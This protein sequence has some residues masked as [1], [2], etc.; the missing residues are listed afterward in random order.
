VR[1]ALAHAAGYPAHRPFYARLG[2]EALARPGLRRADVVALAAAE[3][4][5]YPA[6]ARSLYSDIGFILLG[7]RL[8]RALGARL[9]VLVRDGVSAPLGLTTLGFVDLAAGGAG[10]W[11]RGR[12][13]APTERCVVRGRLVEREVHDLNAYVMGGVAGHAGLFGD[14]GDVAA[15]AHALCA[16]WRGAGAEGG[17]PLVDAEV[18]REFWQPAGVPGS[19]WR[20]GW[21][22]PAATGS[23][24]GDVIARTAVGHLGFTGCSLWVDPERES[25]VAM[26]SNRVHPTARDD[27]RFR[28]LR[29]AV[30]DAA[31]SALGYRS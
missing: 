9:D 13:I 14:A 27:A 10:G 15:V 6:G 21:D 5:E 8:E 30:N 25:F 17:P 18:L 12:P 3:P 28:T 20:L 11:P 4:P 26:L 23:L 16:A 24:A 19:T 31:L 7:D 2:P 1:Q 22:G 29:P